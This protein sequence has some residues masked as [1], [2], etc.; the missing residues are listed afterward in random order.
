MAEYE[1]VH[2]AWERLSRDD[3]VGMSNAVAI[4]A[5]AA[6]TE[7]GR[8]ALAEILLDDAKVALV[9]EDA[10]S[11]LRISRDLPLPP[12]VED[13]RIDA[14]FREN[15]YTGTRLTKTHRLQ[16]PKEFLYFNMAVGMITG[17]LDNVQGARMCLA[18]SGFD[19]VLV[20]MPGGVRKAIG[21]VMVNEFRDTTFG[22][23]NEIIFS[24][25]AVP[26]DVPEALKSV[27]YVN[28]F[29]LQTP[30]DRGATLYLLKLWLDQLSPIDGGNDFLGTNKELGA[31]IFKNTDR[32]TCEFQ[33]VDKHGKWLA[34]GM[35]PRTL[36]PSGT[37]AAR[38]AYHEASAVAG[39]RMPTGTLAAVSVASRPDHEFGRPAT[40]WAFAIDW[41]RPVMQEVTPE[42]VD[43]QLGDADWGQRFANLQFTPMLTAYG[44]QC[45]GQIYQNIGDCPFVVQSPTTRETATSWRR[46]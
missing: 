43:L 2:A 26:E 9:E 17:T 33:S 30:L 1:A 21:T 36:T 13:Q 25:M 35:I 41:R 34:R 31:F 10:L 40:K 32:G 29:S 4:V 24:V 45:V 22:P 16:N 14:Y 27:R 37:V 46:S 15:F 7:G 42:Q 38:S 19:P 8:R 23:Y 5:A 28:G 20:H 44:P 3:H 6:N 11:Y 39:T 18:G 12:G